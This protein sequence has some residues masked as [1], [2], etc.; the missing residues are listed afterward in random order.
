MFSASDPVA[1]ADVIVWRRY[2][3]IEYETKGKRQN[4]RESE[5]A[6]ELSLEHTT[7]QKKGKTQ[8]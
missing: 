1:S 6:Y 7:E 4:D 3:P 5:S 8:F 2:E